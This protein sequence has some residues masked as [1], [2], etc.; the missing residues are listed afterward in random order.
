MRSSARLLCLFG[1]LFLTSPLVAQQPKPVI[2]HAQDKPPN[3][4]RDPETAA[5]LMTV[6]EGFTVEVVAAEPD[7]V[8]PVAMAI[9]ERG[10]F[11]VTE[12]LE[13]PRRE[14]GPGKDRVKILED[15]DGDGRMDKFTVFL[16]GLNIPSGIAVGH[17]GVWV[18]NSPDILFVQDTDGDG[19]ADKQEVVVTG[20][21]RADTHELP[22][23]LTWGPDGWLYG[24]NGVFNH[25]HVKYPKTNPNYKEDHKGW[26]LTCAMFRIHPRTREFQVFCEGTSNPWGIA[27]N[28][29]GEAFVSACVID[30]LWHLVETGYY[31]RQG[32]PYPPFTWKIESIVKHKHQKAAYCGIHYFDSDAYP[33]Q[34]RGKLY[35]GN[36]HGGCI[37]V[38]RVERDGSTYKGIGEPDFLT[39][40]DAWFMPVVQKTG[41][42]GSLYVLD[43]YDR[44]HCYQDA[45][46][47]PAGI[48]RLKGRLY[49]VRYKDTPRVPKEFDL[50][51]ESDEQLIERLRAK[52]DFI[53]STVQRLIRERTVEGRNGGILTGLSV[54]MLNREW[55]Q[56]DRLSAFFASSSYSAE[57][58]L[59]GLGMVASYLKE[60]SE[61]KTMVP[62]IF[63]ALFDD[64]VV[65][66]KRRID[67]KL[68][69][70][71]NAPVGKDASPELRL[72]L[73]I[74]VGKLTDP[75]VVDELL[76]HL[77]QSANDPMLPRI[78]WQNLH[79]RLEE[80]SDRFVDVLR[81]SGYLKAKPVADLIP[82]VVDRIL[83]RQ[84]FDAKP[85]A[86]LFTLLRDD[87][88]EV[89]RDVLAVLATK[90]QTGE[91]KGEKLDQLK[92]A[93]FEPLTPLLT[94]DA[95]HPLGNDAALLAV[96]WGDQRGLAYVRRTFGLTALR[97][98]HRLKALSALVA[99]KD[100][101]LY[102]TVNAVLKSDPSS[103]FQ[104]KVLAVL[105]QLDDPRVAMIVLA[106]YPQLAADLQPRAI[107]LLTQRAAWAKDLLT[108]VGE[109]KIP[110]TAINLNQARRLKDLKDE[111]LTKLLAMNWGQVREGRDPNREQYIAEMKSLIRKSPGDE[112]AGEKAFKKVCAQCHKI[113]GEGAEVGPDITRNGR[114]DFTQLLSNVFD[115]SLVIGAGY[116]SYTV[117]TN[118]GRVLNGLLAE[119]SPQRIVLKVQGGKQE[120]IARSDIDEFNV[121]EISL[122][123]EQLEKQLS[124]QEIVDL[125]AFITLD[126]HPSDPAARQLPGVTQVA[127]RE[128]TNAA[129]YPSIIAEVLPGFTTSESGELG[130]GLLPEYR[131][132]DNVLRTHPISRDKPCALS[133][134]L[135]PPAEKKTK[136]ILD[137]S[138]DPRGDWRLVVR[139]NGQRMADEMISKETC[140]NG[141]RTLTIDLSKFAGQELKLD[142]VNQAND[143]AWEFGYW[144]GARIV[145]E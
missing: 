29:E 3:D 20:F 114:N 116:R 53:R 44:F 10:R 24:L 132:R 70:F 66:T 56:A 21:G 51:K 74:G 139:G 62:W 63:R 87:H 122:M 123:P 60:S 13:Y 134:K 36:I 83:G 141:W 17:G 78:I 88:P 96:S 95:T 124:Q 138:H 144:G 19:K 75:E 105:G 28:D 97:P 86:A 115:P 30:H 48:D 6:P 117:I 85:V 5:K 37:N 81:S 38:D 104:G 129:E 39:A 130:I 45:N 41:P 100:E 119:D 26:P 14:P 94:K 73:V 58:R 143:W 77:S 82:R 49:R 145:S 2:P 137:V 142:L 18:V 9:D 69:E 107:E 106:N 126:K 140:P 34:Y 92:T 133:M 93:M 121:S 113:Y 90:V 12:S 71:R 7:I 91:L 111:Q 72:Q 118:G 64:S 128:S 4:P 25:S 89:G 47:D 43:W 76:F 99:V 120:V 52:N 8:N 102:E 55:S 31:H 32:G 42:D 1:L 23:S 57:T 11:W 127:P 27:F 98:E 40:N 110:A 103:D 54:A 67:L 59:T 79:P 108:A 35:M 61:S 22:N 84:K 15:T 101:E 50:A 33:E 125:F 16:D 80:Q 135:T 136:L 109:K 65:R 131:G 68:T 46:R 112:L